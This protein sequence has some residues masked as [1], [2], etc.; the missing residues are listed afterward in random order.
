MKKKGL[1]L[2]DS[3]YGENKTFFDTLNTAQ[4]PFIYKFHKLLFPAKT[5]W[6][7][8][9]S[10]LSTLLF[11]FRIFLVRNRYS[12]I[13]AWQFVYGTVLASFCNFFH[14]RKCPDIFILNCLISQGSLSSKT[15]GDRFSEKAFSC[16][17]VRKITVLSEGD[18]VLARQ[19]FPQAASK[20]VPIRLGISLR[21]PSVNPKIDSAGYFLSTGFSNRDYTYL[22][23]E[24]AEMPSVKLM[25]VCDGLSLKKEHSNI[26][27][28]HGVFGP[29]YYKA[30]ADCFAVI[31]SS[32]DPH[33]TSGILNLLCAME[34][35]K[36][37]IAT[38]NDC[39]AEYCKPGQEFLQ[40]DKDDK[41][42]L[43]NAISI[44]QTNPSM[45]TQLES[46]A[47]KRFFE[48]YSIECLAQRISNLINNL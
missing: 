8:L 11:C 46:M 22:E 17:F 21:E 40:V 31:I 1:L 26:V 32:K 39:I 35:G 41:S 16:R 25:I 33:S 29:D 2:D 37:I 36:A 10:R 19:I 42:S 3:P 28:V 13:V 4:H 48:E 43:K 12:Q 24:F 18:A 47:K 15:K 20:F 6:Q 27:V 30:I 44:L 45:K 34:F 7:K 14:V 5:K 23:N 9:K 38:K